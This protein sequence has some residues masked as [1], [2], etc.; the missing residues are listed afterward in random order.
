MIIRRKIYCQDL[1]IQ[2]VR[3][4]FRLSMY[5][6]SHFKDL[7]VTA[8][9]PL[10][11][12]FLKIIGSMLLRPG[13]WFFPDPFSKIDS[14]CAHVFFNFQINKIIFHPWFFVLSFDIAFSKNISF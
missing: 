10:K 7:S 4:A 9:L 6:Y 3:V 11:R 12:Y 14:I 2:K 1:A 5:A 8:F 13:K